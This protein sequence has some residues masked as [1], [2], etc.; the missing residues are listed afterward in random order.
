MS[1]HDLAVYVSMPFIAAV[2]GYVTKRVA[3]KMM[4]EPIEF[5]GIK[6]VL[7]WQGILP[8][9]AERMAATATD[10]LINNLLSPREVVARLDP[11]RIAREVEQ[12]LLHAVEAITREVMSQYQPDLWEMLPGA[13]QRLLIRQVQAEAPKIVKNLLAEIIED[14]DGV[15]DIRHMAV[16]NLSRDKVLLNRLIRDIAKPEFRFIARCGTYFGFALG[17]VQLGVWALTHQPLIMPLF[18]LLV[19]WFTDW[20]ALKM[21]FFPREP[22]RYLGLVTWQGLFQKRREQVAADYG[23]LIAREVITVPNVVEEVLRGPKSDRLFTLIQNEVQRSVDAQT[24]LVKPFVVA[25]VGSRRYQEMKVAAAAKAI[26]HIPAAARSA[27]HYAEDALDVRNTIVERMTRLS[28]TEFEG[29]LRPA[30]RQD[31]WKLITVGAVIGFLVGELQVLLLL[32]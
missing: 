24:G 15:L 9:N 14:I 21:I 23:D 2:V 30:F 1:W 25:A 32:G 7:G 5:V 22:K 16:T 17:L 20:L 10:T 19:G 11:E 3:I 26:E 13:A 29:I 18:G 27:E 12:P 4:F 28:P 8:K 6:P 31:E